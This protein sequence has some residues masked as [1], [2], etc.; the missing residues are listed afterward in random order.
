M[1]KQPSFEELL[2]KI[3]KVD[4]PLFLET[5]VRAKM[6][7]SAAKTLPLSWQ[8]SGALA[9]FVLVAINVWAIRMS[10]AHTFGYWR[11][12]DTENIVASMHLETSN[13][14]YHE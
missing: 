4:P 2:S 9:L 1:K 3:E 11:Q 14:L 13:Q 5:R 12:H 7:A 6:S 10:G 8:W